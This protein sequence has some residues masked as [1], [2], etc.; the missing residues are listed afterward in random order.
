MGYRRSPDKVKSVRDWRAFV[1]R[2]QALV[3]VAGLPLIVIESAD[4]WEDFV[5]H[6]ILDHHDDPTNFS[7]DRINE[8]QYNALIQLVERYF[9]SGYAYFAASALRYEDQLRMYKKFD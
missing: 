4:H 8:R 9:D 3:D 2:N 7:V 1:A 6:G 5:M